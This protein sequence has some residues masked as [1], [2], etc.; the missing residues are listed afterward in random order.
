MLEIGTYTVNSVSVVSV[1]VASP[2]LSPTMSF[3]GAVIYPLDQNGLPDG[4]ITEPGFVRIEAGQ[5]T[6][7]SF[8]VA[9]HRGTASGVALFLDE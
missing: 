2:P 1:P 5:E 9:D 4:F 8:S 3:F 6:T 7:L